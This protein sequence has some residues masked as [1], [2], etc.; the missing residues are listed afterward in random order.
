MRI[1][2]R[3]IQPYTICWWGVPGHVSE[4]YM[5]QEDNPTV[6]ITVKQYKC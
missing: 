2:A 4:V 5:E 6:P 1:E 3:R